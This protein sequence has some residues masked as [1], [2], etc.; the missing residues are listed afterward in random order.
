MRVALA[1]ATL[2]LASPAAA[3]DEFAAVREAIQTCTACHWDGGASKMP[4][5]PI[6][7]GQQYYYLYLQL[8]DFKSG[9][10]HSDIMGPLVQPLQ[11]EQM[12]LLAQFFSKQKWP[13]IGHA[14]ESANVE[15]ARRAEESAGCIGCHLGD[16][17]GNSAVPR[18]AGQHPEYLKRT[19]LDF[20][21]KVRTNAPA[22]VALFATF[23]EQEIAA[24]ADHLASLT[25]YQSSQ[26]A[27]I[28]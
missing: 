26:G 21:N 1:V 11:P 20:K 25:V 22:M 18:L 14:A 8:K 27:E 4:E 12:K 23:S 9:A 10:R 13:T 3:Q 17:R 16:F 19:M 7:A 2:L 15:I 6:L 5:N 24:F 28:Q